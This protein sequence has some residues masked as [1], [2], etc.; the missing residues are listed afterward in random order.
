MMGSAA[1]MRSPS[2]VSL[3][4]STPCVD[5]CWGPMFR[6]MSSV[7]SSLAPSPIPTMRSVFIVASSPLGSPPHRR[8]ASGTR[9]PVDYG[10]MNPSHGEPPYEP[11]ADPGAQDA[12]YPPLPSGQPGQGG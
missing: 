2:R 3:S 11:A 4:L 5:G 10:P 12:A 9:F 8:M 6:V 1:E 7:A